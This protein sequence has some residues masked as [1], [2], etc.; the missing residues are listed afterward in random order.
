MNE[1][2]GKNKI[3]TI[4][5]IIQIYLQSKKVNKY[6]VNTGIINSADDKPNQIV[7]NAFP[8]DLV[9]YLETV[10]VAVCDIIPWPENLIKNIA[11]NKKVIEEIFE[12]K[13]HEKDKRIV[14][15]EANLKIFISSIFF[16]SQIR[17]KLLNKVADA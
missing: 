5:I 8:L 2:N 13:K 14:T 1:A 9:K 7:L 17:I 12:K 3:T 16:P 10:V 11:K 4:E 15:N 6:I